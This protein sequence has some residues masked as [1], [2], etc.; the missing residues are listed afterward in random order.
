MKGKKIKIALISSSG[1][2]F[3]ELKNIA[4]VA[5]KYDNF[6]ITERVE[7][8]KTTL[9]RKVYL[10]P[11]INRQEKLFLFKLALLSFK[12]LFIFIKERPTHVIT[13]GA[14]CAYPL[15]RIAKL[16]KKKVIYIESY[17][18]V[19]DLSLT[20]KKVYNHAD[21][22]L[23]QWPELAEKY[24]KAVYVGSFYGGGDKWYSFHLEHKNFN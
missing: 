20:G 22:F 1:G 21:L 2:H 8:F 6:L 17:A 3:S 19:Y 10:V 13:T 7:N 16:F 18:R 9:S 5:E 14:L 15:I 24:E 4:K 23:V 11:E 12:Q